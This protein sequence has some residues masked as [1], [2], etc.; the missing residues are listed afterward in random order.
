MADLDAPTV[1]AHAGPALERFGDRVLHL[2]VDGLQPVATAVASATSHLGKPPDPRPF[3]GHITLARPHGRSR[4]KL[5]RLAGV[6]FE[7]A[8]HA[9]TISLVASALGPG[10]SRYDVL[11]EFRLATHQS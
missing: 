1:T 3:N 7:A 4:V 2:P 9:E 10:G 8:W 11:Q 5:A 6:P